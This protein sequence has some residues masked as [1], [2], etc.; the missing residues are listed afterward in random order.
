MHLDYMLL[1]VGVNTLCCCINT[2]SLVP[3][4]HTMIIINPRH[5]CAARVTV[6]GSVVCVCACVRVLYSTSHLSNVSTNGMT[7]LT[8]NESQTVFSE[9]ASL[10]S[11]SSSGIV[12]LLTT[13][14]P[15]F[16]PTRMCIIFYHVAEVTISLRRRSGVL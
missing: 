15:F 10:Q 6:V 3:T 13:S 11:S 2:Y 16:I 9:N 4:S 7:Y 14:L 12:Q 8:D 1:Y 5:A